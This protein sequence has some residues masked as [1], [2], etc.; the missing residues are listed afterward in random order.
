MSDSTEVQEKRASATEA[1]TRQLLA[2]LAQLGNAR[3]QDDA[4]VFEGKKFILPATFSNDLRGAIKFLRDYQ[5]QQEEEHRF[6]RTFNYRP[7]DGAH[8][9]S[10]AL[11]KVFGTTGIAKAQMSFFGKIPPAMITINVGHND[12]IQVPWGNIA[13]PIFD[14]MMTTQVAHDPVYGPLFRLTVEAPRKYA[15]YIEGLF[16]AIEEELRTNSI[17]KGKAIDGAEDPEFLDLDSVQAE[18]VVY[19]DALM[20]QIETSIW[21]SLD[22]PQK[23]RDFGIPLKRSILLTGPYGTGKTLTATL[24]AQRAVRADEPWTFIY[25]RPEHTLK[26]VLATA[27]L[28]APAIVFFEDV[29]AVA[30]D[31]DADSVSALLDMFDGISAKGAEIMAILTTNH[32]DRIHKGMLRPGR[33]DAVIEYGNLDRN[34]V[35]KLVRQIAQRGGLKIHK[36]VDFDAVFQAMEGYLPAFCKEVVDRAIRYSITR[37]AGEPTELTTNDLVD[38]A[39]GLRPQWEM[40]Q[41]AGEGERLPTLD[42][43]LRKAVSTETAQALATT[44]VTRSGEYFGELTVPE[45]EPANGK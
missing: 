19:S 27:R 12:T 41:D 13:V 21:S 36:S 43:S 4:L 3:V 17:Y 31:G 5:A 1:N 29:D 22:H 25:C 23:M 15:A 30:N 45:I 44:R 8:A 2:T 16:I 35:E 39:E 42:A 37:G 9:L 32:P 11:K 24:T 38:S 20:R 26:D 40:M 34:G 28:Y 18:H 10:A 6:D 14:G 7:K 33:L